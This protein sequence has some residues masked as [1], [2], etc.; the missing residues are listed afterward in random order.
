VFN[1]CKLTDQYI[2]Y[3]TDVNNELFNGCKLTDQQI[4]HTTD[5]NIDVWCHV[6]GTDHLPTH[7]SNSI[8]KNQNIYKYK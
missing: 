5:V 7:L 4:Q 8:F 2:E 1:G 6:S 3:T